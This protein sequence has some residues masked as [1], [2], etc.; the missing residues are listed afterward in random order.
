MRFWRQMLVILSVLFICTQLSLNEGFLQKFCF[1]KHNCLPIEKSRLVGR[2]LETK[3]AGNEFT[4]IG[5]GDLLFTRSLALEG[6][7]HDFSHMWEEIQHLW[8]DVKGF[9]IVISN[10]EGT[11]GKVDVTGKLRNGSCSYKQKDLFTNGVASGG[12][13]Y[14]P[15]LIRDLSKSG[16][17]MFTLANNHAFD[18]GFEGI[19]QTKTLLESAGF[20]TIGTLFAGSKGLNITDF[21]HVEEQGGWR[22]GVVSCTNILCST[23][24]KKLFAPT[25]LVRRQILYCRD[26]TR[27]LKDNRIKHLV[28]VLV[29]APHWGSQFKDGITKEVKALTKEFVNAGVDVILG[30]H[31]HIPQRLEKIRSIDGRTVIVSYSLGSFTSG[32]G[33]WSITKVKERASA[34]LFMTFSNSSGEIE[35]KIKYEPVCEVWTEN[36]LRKLVSTKKAGPKCRAEEEVIHRLMWEGSRDES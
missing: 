19:S 14:H 29:V 32:L 7:R 35:V 36:K 23:C 11:V 16:I 2:D 34:V 8:D 31:P 5:L 1:V 13:N 25:D 18:R 28:D 27:M 20:G 12:F 33:S 9:K 24:R 3:E 22:I 6:Y 4:I 30:N 26:A 21:L 15:K 17:S 10:F